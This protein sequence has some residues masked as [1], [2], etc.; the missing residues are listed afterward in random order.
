MNEALTKQASPG[1]VHDFPET[2][3]ELAYLVLS[4]PR[5]GSTML[6]SALVASRQ[7]GHPAEYLH[8]KNI[9]AYTKGATEWSLAEYLAATI[10][11]R[12]SPN[13]RFGLKLHAH[14]YQ[15]L[16]GA[17]PGAGT[18]FLGR[19]GRFIRMYRRSKL[20]A[21]ISDVLANERA[22]WNISDPTKRPPERDFR[23]DDVEK[24]AMHLARIAA[25]ER[26]WQDIAARQAAKTIAIAYED[27]C[28]DPEGEIARA[29]LHLGVEIDLANIPKPTTVRLSGEGSERIK[30]NFLRAINGGSRLGPPSRG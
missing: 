2:P 1:A 23:P 5:T 21:A 19:F 20:D 15:R 4:A 24:I 3:V 22:V 11:R 17:S 30:A 12:T 16:F 29:L 18:A 14:Q 6:C 13:G 26:F 25:E 9:A 7:A 10:R 27:M 28:A 8:E